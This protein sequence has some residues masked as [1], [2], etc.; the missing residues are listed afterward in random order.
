MLL[1]DVEPFFD[2]ELDPTISN[3]WVFPMLMWQGMAHL[4]HDQVIYHIYSQLFAQLG[5]RM[6]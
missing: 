2:N 3:P 5:T 6:Q 1:S 4:H